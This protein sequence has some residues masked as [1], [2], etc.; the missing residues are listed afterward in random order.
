MV[1]APITAIVFIG[2]PFR[3]DATLISPQKGIIIFDSD[4]ERWKNILEGIKNEFY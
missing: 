3:K 1:P 2:Y 4:I